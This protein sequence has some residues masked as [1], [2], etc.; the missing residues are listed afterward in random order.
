MNAS[1]GYIELTMELFQRVLSIMPEIIHSSSATPEQF[2]T[3][4]DRLD[5][6][7]LG[8]SKIGISRSTPPF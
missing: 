8:Q 6:G 1:T 5:E 3:V 7:D 2:V 4:S